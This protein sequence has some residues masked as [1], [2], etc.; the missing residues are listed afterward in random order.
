M[1]SAPVD[2]TD[3]TFLPMTESLLA[4]G[5]PPAAGLVSRLG[6]ELW[7]VP[8]LSFDTRWSAGPTIEDWQEATI[9]GPGVEG[10]VVAV[11]PGSP[12]PS[13]LADQDLEQWLSTMELPFALWFA[14]LAA[15]SERCATGGQLVAVVDRTDPKDA[16]GWGAQTAIADAVTTMVRSL[17]MVHRPRGV[18]MSLVTSPDRLTGSAGGVTDEL[19]GTVAMLLSNQGDGPATSVIHLGGGL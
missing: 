16:A 5:T 11:W 7:E 15:G 14:A 9:E 6:G 1:M 10:V 4:I 17:A 8:A 12:R 3:G 19:V 13:A 18:R 2:P